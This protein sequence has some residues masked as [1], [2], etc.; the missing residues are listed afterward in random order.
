MILIRM[1]IDGLRGWILPREDLRNR[2]LPRGDLRN[3]ICRIC[4]VEGVTD[5]I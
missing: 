1:P 5:P 2:I 3:R 4:G